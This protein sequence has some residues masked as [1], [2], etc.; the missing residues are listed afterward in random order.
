MLSKLDVVA[1]IAT[2]PGRGGI[3][4]IR[5]S[6]KDLSSFL[7]P[8]FGQKLIPRHATYVPFKS[9]EGVVLDYGIGLYFPGPHSYTGEDVIELQGHGGTA[10]L[11]LIL[12]RCF[13]LG[14]RPA[15]AGEFTQRAFLN[16]KLDLVQAESVIDLINATT[17]QGVRSAMRSLQG[18]FSQAIHR[19]L[20][21]L[22]ELRMQIEASLDFPEEEIPAQNLARQ[23][24]KL[25]SIKF[26]LDRIFDLAKQGGI[27]REGAHVVLVGRP[28][29]GKSS[30]LN[31]LSGE[32]VALVSEVAGTTRDAIR[33]AINIDG[34][35]FHIIDTAGLRE[36]QDVVEKMG[37]ER[38]KQAIDNADLVLLL[39]DAIK[40]DDSATEKILE[41]IPGAIPR[42]HVINKIDLVGM[43]AHEET[44]DEID[45]IYVSAKTEEGINLLKA[46]L[47]KML[48]WHGESGAFMA[49]ARHLESLNKAKVCLARTSVNAATMELL[50]EDLRLS[51]VALS[52]ITGRFTSDDL[53][54]EI[55]SRFCIGK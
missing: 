49:R 48:G 12:Q 30:L 22:I 28:N 31:R 55:F 50:A 26:E 53:L 8:L 3:G 29:V 19:L 34:V 27:L 15:E 45:Y 41:Q 20:A 44:K 4:V 18:D 46:K 25:N 35:P 39:E 38:T 24:N 2:A 21:Q 10:V 11:G 14:A 42:L 47:L 51:Q 32:E 23:E 5:L 6:G 17:E 13:S 1:A 54:G 36:S 7:L 43:A 16:N 52:E 9:A 33:Q 40:K 37:M